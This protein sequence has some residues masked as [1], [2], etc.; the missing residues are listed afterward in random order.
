MHKQKLYKHDLCYS[1]GVA[2]DATLVDGWRDLSRRFALLSCALDR[3]LH[4]AHSIGMSEFEVL[5]RLAEA[6]CTMVR[7]N[8]IADT[9][10]LSQS[11]L[12]RAVARLERLGLVER[13]LCAR[14]RRGIF[15]RLTDGGR[16]RHAAALPT[17]RAVLAEHLGTDSWESPY[18]RLALGRRELSAE[19]TY[20]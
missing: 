5:D 13:A 8:E 3:E 20:P 16:V 1:A 4:E 7:M 6:A 17:Q 11:A 12:S 19:E 18:G 10:H 14:D 15:V 9:V 2:S